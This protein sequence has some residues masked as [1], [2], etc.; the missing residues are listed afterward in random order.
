MSGLQPAF[1]GFTNV[2][3]V[4]G[5]V[6]GVDV[7][8]LVVNLLGSTGQGYVFTTGEDRSLEHEVGDDGVGVEL[9]RPGDETAGNRRLAGRDSNALMTCMSAEGQSGPTRSKDRIVGGELPAEASGR[10][11][12]R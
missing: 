3:T 11:R 6:V 8:Q 10:G 9:V 2:D 5:S 12:R 1:L 7:E 4:L